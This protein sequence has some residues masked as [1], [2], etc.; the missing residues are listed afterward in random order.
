MHNRNYEGMPPL[1]EDS[2]ESR[3]SE[4]EE[5]HLVVEGRHTISNSEGKE[6]LLV[7]SFL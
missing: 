3:N 7:P 6:D 1:D 4:D 2:C 5:T